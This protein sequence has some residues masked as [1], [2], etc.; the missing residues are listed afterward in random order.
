MAKETYRPG[1]MAEADAK[2]T[3]RFFI[4]AS[5]IVGLIILITII[6]NNLYFHAYFKRAPMIS[7][8]AGF[9]SAAAWYWF[10]WK[11]SVDFSYGKKASMTLTL[12]ILGVGLLLTLMLLF[13]FNL[14][15]HGIEK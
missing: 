5:I 11:K 6:P 14:D 9:I 10:L 12:V 7:K 15:L 2:S 13:G 8:I 4:G 3:K 1:S